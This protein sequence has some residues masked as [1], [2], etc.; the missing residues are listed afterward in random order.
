[1]RKEARNNG[2]DA[3]FFAVEGL[4][5]LRKHDCLF[6]PRGGH[7]LAG[8]PNFGGLVL[9]CIEAFFKVYKIHTPSHRSR[10]NFVEMF[11]NFAKFCN[12][13]V[14]NYFSQNLLLEFVMFRLYCLRKFA[15]I[16]QNISNFD[17]FQF[18]N[19]KFQKNCEHPR[20]M[21]KEIVYVWLAGCFRKDPPSPSSHKQILKQ[22]RKRGRRPPLPQ[23][24]CRSAT[25]TALPES[26]RSGSSR[27][28]SKPVM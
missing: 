26:C 24:V 10:F 14:I 1:M 28:K 12:F 15:G 23:Q 5:A 8:C 21:Q 27:K 17:E 6:D 4:A 7:R 2:G 9:F 20:E 16:S 25:A 18:A 11:A 13:F 3:V 19:S 22:P